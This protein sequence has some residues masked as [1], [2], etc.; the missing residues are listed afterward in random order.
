[1]VTRNTQDPYSNSAYYLVINFK[2]HEKYNNDKCYN[3]KLHGAMTVYN[4]G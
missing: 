1:M 3:K 4:R 2:N